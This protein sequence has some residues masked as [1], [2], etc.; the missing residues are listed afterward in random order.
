LA[1]R[2]QQ[3]VRH[4][5]HPTPQ[6]IDPLALIILF[7]SP[8]LPGEP[9]KWL[10]PN[11]T[12]WHSPTYAH[13]DNAFIPGTGRFTPTWRGR[14]RL[15]RN[16]KDTLA[17][18]YFYQHDP[19]IAPYS[20]SSVPGFTEHLDS[21]AQVASITNTFIVKSNLSTTQTLGFIREK[22]WG[23]NEQPFGPNSIPGGS[24]AP[25]PSTC[26]D[27][28]TFPASP[29]TTCWATRLSISPP[30]SAMLS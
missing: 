20:Y 13:L 14:P 19:T 15:Q 17:L 9:G 25:G 8:A 7:N 11:D 28:T 12:Q 16:Q 5:P 27:R 4:Q 6:C 24:R 29:S 30:A 2:C 21:G 26:S 1:N 10:I 18:K 3:L 23:D 22:N